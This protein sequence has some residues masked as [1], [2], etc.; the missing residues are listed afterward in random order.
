AQS[1]TRQQ[2]REA[3]DIFLHLDK[4]KAVQ[5]VITYEFQDG[6]DLFLKK[7]KADFEIILNSL[8]NFEIQDLYR[9]PDSKDMAI[10]AFRMDKRA[11]AKLKYPEGASI[12]LGPLI[13]TVI[14]PIPTAK[15]IVYPDSNVIH[16]IFAEFQRIAK[17]AES[18]GQQLL[19][20]P[21][22]LKTD[23]DFGPRIYLE[24]GVWTDMRP[25]QD[26]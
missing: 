2:A 25:T 3:V 9:L 24:Q 18:K 23:G 22:H 21:M 8:G 16:I 19:L 1:K 10:V 6:D 7:H 15:K 12:F 17:A 4:L 5:D 11:A 20:V 14:G 13:G 26:K